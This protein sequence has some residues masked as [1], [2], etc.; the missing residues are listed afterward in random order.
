MYSSELD[1]LIGNHYPKL[2]T[3]EWWRQSLIV[4]LVWGIVRKTN[5]FTEWRL[6]KK[7]LLEQE[8]FVVCLRLL[9]FYH[10][11]VLVG[12]MLYYVGASFDPSLRQVYHLRLCST[13]LAIL[14]FWKCVQSLGYTHISCTILKSCSIN[15]V[16]NNLSCLYRQQYLECI[17]RYEALLYWD[18]DIFSSR[19]IEVSVPRISLIICHW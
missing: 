1:Q 17:T 11:S 5:P 4:R 7:R 9:Q 8:R 14:Y 16:T 15:L 13:F 2:C 10:S 12:N 6:N 3:Y 18:S 19:C